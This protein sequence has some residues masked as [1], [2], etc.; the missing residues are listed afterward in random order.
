MRAARLLLL[1]HPM[2]LS[3][4][5]ARDHNG[6]VRPCHPKRPG[7]RNGARLL[8]LRLLLLLLLLLLRLRCLRLG[9]ARIGNGGVRP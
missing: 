4:G 6:G 5:C 3:L 1:L 9:R 7:P 2:L 8:L